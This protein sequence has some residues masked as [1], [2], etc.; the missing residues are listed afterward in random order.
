L[1]ALILLSM[2]I[3]MLS[4]QEYSLREKMFLFSMAFTEPA[5]YQKTV[6]WDPAPMGFAGQSVA[7]PLVSQFPNMAMAIRPRPS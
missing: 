3:S 5:W 4:Q 2:N 7:W 1:K 6:H